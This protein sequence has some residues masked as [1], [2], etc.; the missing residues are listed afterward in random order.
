MVTQK[1]TDILTQ[2]LITA[3]T[4]HTIILDRQIP[5]TD[6]VE[7]EFEPQEGPVKPDLG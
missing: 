1:T 5:S 6:R 7:G 3:S 2:Y 4:I